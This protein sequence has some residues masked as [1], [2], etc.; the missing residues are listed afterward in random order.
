M[1][2]D[3]DVT[4]GECGA[5][6]RFV[7]ESQHRIVMNSSCRSAKRARNSAERM[8]C[9]WSAD[10]LVRF[11]GLESWFFKQRQSSCSLS[12]SSSILPHRKSIRS[13]ISDPHALRH[14]LYASPCPLP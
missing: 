10:A 8:V 2:R 9:G 5:S 7:T 14:S 11:G 4:A 1:D 3:L 13:Q 6:D 12:H